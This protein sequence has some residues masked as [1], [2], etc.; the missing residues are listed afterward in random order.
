MSAPSYVPNAATKRGA[1]EK[2]WLKLIWYQEP[3]TAS[4]EVAVLAVR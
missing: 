1:A 4:G 2:V 3:V